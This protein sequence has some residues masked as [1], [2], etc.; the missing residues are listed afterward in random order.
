MNTTWLMSHAFP[1]VPGILTRIF[2]AG[3]AVTAPVAATPFT[4]SVAATVGLPY[5]TMTFGA[6]RDIV[7]TL[8]TTLFQDHSKYCPVRLIPNFSYTS[9]HVE[10]IGYLIGTLLLTNRHRYCG[11]VLIDEISA[12]LIISPV[13]PYCQFSIVA[14]N[15]WARESLAVAQYHTESVVHQ[16]C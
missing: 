10:H 3:A 9:M 4:L 14:H 5:A 15:R 8:L 1:A 13:K 16:S 7:A 12:N 2:Q 6:E 11:V